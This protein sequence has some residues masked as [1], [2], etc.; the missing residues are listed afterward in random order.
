M[1]GELPIEEHDRNTHKAKRRRHSRR[2]RCGGEDDRID[3]PDQVVEDL[4]LSSGALVGVAEKNVVVTIAGAL[5][6]PLHSVSKKGVGDVRNDDTDRARRPRLQTAR[7]LVKTETDLS[8]C[9]L[10]L[11]LRP[12]AVSV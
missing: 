12:N 4:F 3:P 8:D 11:R 6:D 5:L 7:R 1:V 10:D 2:L 9:R